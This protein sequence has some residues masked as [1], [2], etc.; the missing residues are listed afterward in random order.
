MNNN[1]WYITVITTMLAMTLKMFII[2]A[3]VTIES[4]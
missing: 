3:I 2:I 1:T 4:Y